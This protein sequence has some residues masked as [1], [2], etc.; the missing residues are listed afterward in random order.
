MARAVNPQISFADLEFQKQGVA[1]DDTLRTISDFLAEHG[2]LVERVRQDLVRGLK[3]GRTGRNGLSAESV[4]RSLVLKRIKNWDLRELR[5]RIHDSYTLR[6]FTGF[7]SNPVPKH[8]AFARAYSRL[9]PETFR[10]VN[11]AMI[12]AVVAMGIEDGKKL[13]VDTTVAET[14][15]HHPTDSTLLWDT[16]RVVSRLV[17]KLC[18]I[19]PAARQGF[20]DRTRRARR[21]MAEISRMD[22]QERP[23]R[24]RRKYKELIRITE[25]VM[26]SA[27]AVVAKTEAVEGLEPLQALAVDTLREQIVLYCGRG[28]RVVD[29]SRRRVLQGEQVPAEEKI[30][31]IFEEHTDMIKRGK[32]DKPVEFGH[33]I[34]LA[35][36]A[37]GFITDYLVLPGN[38]CDEKQVEPSLQR[39][40]ERFKAVPELYAADRGFYSQDNVER[41]ERLQVKLV[42]IPSRGQKSTERQL[43]EKTDA[44]KKGQR[45]RAG[46]EGRISVL[47][48]GRGMKRCLNEGEERFE[49]FVAAAVLA[50]NLL[51]LAAL[52]KKKRRPKRMTRRRAA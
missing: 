52:L 16:V 10:A 43:F 4:L 13:R 20:H 12:E 37:R 42:C 41:C 15:I 1:L 31:S 49:T 22:R 7:F 6:E 19:L 21:R 14:D 30:F 46:I 26:A 23:R 9:R 47:F 35:E 28:G 24:Q 50:N 51:V 3:N 48:R 44:F 34:F 29:Q 8:D 27:R 5:E 39:H 32:V 38:P 40:Q 36:S 18:A 45:F 25:E 2:E 11:Q 33:K 17:R